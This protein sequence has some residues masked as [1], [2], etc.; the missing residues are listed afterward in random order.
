M[1]TIADDWRIILT[2]SAAVPAALSTTS[3]TVITAATNIITVDVTVVAVT[4]NVAFIST[5]VMDSAA[6]VIP[7]I[8]R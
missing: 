3:T 2:R 5:I 1:S 6:A 4:A 8:L 7:F